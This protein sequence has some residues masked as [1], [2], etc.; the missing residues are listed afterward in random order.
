M[1]H[2]GDVSF[3]TIILIICLFICIA[4]PGGISMLCE[5]K[6]E[7]NLPI[8]ISKELTVSG[9]SYYTIQGELKNL[10]EESVKIDK[11]TIV[12]AG[13]KNKVNYSGTVVLENI[14]VS[15]NSYYQIY[16]PGH[17]FLNENGGQIPSGVLTYARI[18]ECVIGGETISLKKF[19][20][21]SFVD[22][23]VQPGGA[24]F[25]II[26]GS[27]ALFCSIGL[28]IYKIKNK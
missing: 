9:Y 6:K 24:I 4:L 3:S 5:S 16:S 14:E 15:A 26:I 17:S 21:E 23:G 27:I 25:A 11:L 28:I 2:Y 19:D 7:Y 10:T 1:K 22:Q 12:V 13:S 18:N 20:G 8:Y